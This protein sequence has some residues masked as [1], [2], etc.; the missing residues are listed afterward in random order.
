MDSN[1]LPDAVDQNAEHHHGDQ[2]VEEHA[3]FDNQRHAVGQTSGGQED[4]VFQRQQRQHL[5]QRLAPVDHHEEAN[6][7][8]EMATAS[9]LWPR[10]P[11][12]ASGR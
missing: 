1:D 6:Q 3:E 2:H 11:A 4:A 10:L 7:E 12:P 9:V 8:Q 5:R